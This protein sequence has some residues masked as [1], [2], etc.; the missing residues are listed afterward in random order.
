MTAG[1]P[2]SKS[3]CGSW[4]ESSQL[5]ENEEISAAAFHAYSLPSFPLT[6]WLGYKK[7]QMVKSCPS[8]FPAQQGFF[9]PLHLLSSPYK[10]AFSIHPSLASQGCPHISKLYQHW[11]GPIHLIHQKY[12]SGQPQNTVR[13]IT[14]AALTCTSAV[15]AWRVFLCGSWIFYVQTLQCVTPVLSSPMDIHKRGDSIR[16]QSLSHAV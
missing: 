13:F 11:N 10:S 4:S 2:E 9:N 3:Y 6:F 16:E 12:F 7:T 14:T 5:L 8:Y 15:P 1:K